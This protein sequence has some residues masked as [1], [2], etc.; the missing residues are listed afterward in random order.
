[1][2]EHEKHHIFIFS[3]SLYEF[4]MYKLGTLISE[5]SFVFALWVGT[6]C[7]HLVCTY[8]EFRKGD[9]HQVGNRKPH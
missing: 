7:Q 2:V 1:M 9:L 3:Y 5:Y 4:L 8:L 6:L